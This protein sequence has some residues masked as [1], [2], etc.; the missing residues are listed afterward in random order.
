MED[1]SQATVNFKFHTNFRIKT[2][3]TKTKTGNAIPVFDQSIFNRIYGS[4]KN[5]EFMVQ[6]HL[7]VHVISE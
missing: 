5:T 2:D 1:P 7:E 3:Y 6:L 4:I